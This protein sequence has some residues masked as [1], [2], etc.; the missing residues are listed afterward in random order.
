MNEESGAR[1]PTPEVML[2]MAALC[3]VAALN[4]GRQDECQSRS[5]KLKSTND[6]P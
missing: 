1:G 5:G 6:E 2:P 3:L 4:A